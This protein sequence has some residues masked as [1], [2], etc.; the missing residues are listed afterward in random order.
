MNI[1]LIF[2]L[3]PAQDIETIAVLV[4]ALQKKLL[5]LDQ[6]DQEQDYP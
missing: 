6:Q 3:L 1:F 5:P 2:R 4:L